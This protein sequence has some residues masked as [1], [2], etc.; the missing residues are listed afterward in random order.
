MRGILSKGIWVSSHHSVHF[1][2]PTILYADF[3]SMKLK[4]KKKKDHILGRGMQCFPCPHSRNAFSEKYC[5]SFHTYPFLHPVRNREI[6]FV[7]GTLLDDVCVML[8]HRNLIPNPA[9]WSTG[10]Q[11]V[12][13][14]F[15][16]AGFSGWLAPAWTQAMMN[17]PH[18]P[19][20]VL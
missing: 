18:F 3:T 1:K 2:Y 17:R 12:L 20:W 7:V 13:D 9:V 6:F 16:T 8:Q 4:L 14:T 10:C 19:R 15:F 11:L 5:S